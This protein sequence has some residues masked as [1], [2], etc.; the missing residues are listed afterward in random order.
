MNYRKIISGIFGIAAAATVN[1]AASDA[2][3]LSTT[4]TVTQVA[5][6][7]TGSGT[8]QIY[9]GGTWYYSFGSS[10]TCS[11]SD[12]ETRKQWMSLAQTA[13][14]TGRQLNINY[15]SCTGGPSLDYVRVQ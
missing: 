8:V 15:T 5:W 11:T 10:G 9:C 3:A 13:L 12:M 1:L 14:L 6:S 7:P 4:C 2:L